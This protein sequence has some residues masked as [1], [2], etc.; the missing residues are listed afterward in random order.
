MLKILAGDQVK[1][2]DA[3]HVRTKGIS[4]LEL[5]ENAAQAF[6]NWWNG[7]RFSLE[8]P[9]CIFCGAGNNGGDGFA[10]ARLLHQS[11]FSVTLFKC[12][13]DS[14]ILSLDAA[15]NLHRLP[16]EVKVKPWVEFDPRTDGVLID[17]FLGVGLK[18]A[19]RLEAIAIIQRINVFEGPVISVDIP[20]GLP[21]DGVLVGDC[22]VADV[23]VTFAFPKL[24]LLFPEHGNLTGELVLADIGIEEREYNDFQSPYF[25]L[26]ESDVGAFHRTFSRFSHKGDYGKIL[27]LVGSK[28]KM[29]AAVLAASASLRTGSGLVTAWIPEQERQ[30]LQVA[31]PEAMCRFDSPEDLEK[32]DAVGVGPGIGLEDGAERLEF[33]FANYKK[34][35]VIDADAIT[36]LAQNT[37]LI[38][39]IPK[40]SILT[41]HLVEFDRVLGKTT[42]H[43]E[44]L[45]KASDFCRT[46]GVNMVIKGANS[47]ICLADGR[48]LFNSSGSQYMATG[49]SGDVLTGMLTSFLGQGYSPEQ[50]MI[51]GVYQHGLAG[52][53][54]GQSKRRGAIASDIVDAIP[55]TFLKLNIS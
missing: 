48:Q 45:A 42:N 46:Y 43:L 5:M 11:G 18:G 51:C 15:A 2:L 3:T 10:I 24:S 4:S 16:P 40:G 41:P 34:P 14:A 30:I 49:G 32:F 33:I 29:G 23:T 54:A 12:F 55:T 39:L 50:A 44:R 21:S 37:A 28:G 20:S 52:E 31:V 35:V 47:V 19:L 1:I 6:V 17:A 13:G 38:P 7:A 36:L 8:M 9:I 22:V 27:L 53:I 25:F 26:R